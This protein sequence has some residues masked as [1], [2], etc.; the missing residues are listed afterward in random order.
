MG[1]ST[2]G[3]HVDQCDCFFHSCDDGDLI[4]CS[5]VVVSK[6]VGLVSDIDII[7]VSVV[8]IVDVSNLIVAIG[9]R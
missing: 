1:S 3:L 9:R 8:D 7:H 4:A 6:I 2:Q 5:D